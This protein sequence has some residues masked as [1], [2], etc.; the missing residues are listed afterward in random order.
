MRRGQNKIGELMGARQRRN[1]VVK[2][3]CFPDFASCYSDKLRHPFV[4]PLF[5]DLTG[6]PP[7]LIFVDVDEIMRP[8]RE[9]MEWKFFLQ[10]TY[11]AEI[12]CGVHF[13]SVRFECNPSV[14]GIHRWD[15]RKYQFRSYSADRGSAE[16]PSFPAVRLPNLQPHRCQ[17]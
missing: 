7:S 15:M 13:N 3:H 12:I 8:A 11:A 16:K 5:G 17:P 2:E 4:S 1:I 9:T 6:M 14:G 10:H